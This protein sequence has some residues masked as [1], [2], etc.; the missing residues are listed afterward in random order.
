[1]GTMRLNE[2]DR[3]EAFS[4]SV[5]AVIITIMAFN[6]KPPLGASIHALNGVLP[7]L[8][9]YILSF[10]IVGT[11]WNNHH[12]LL[13]ATERTS[14][15]VMWTN[16]F[17]LFWLSLMPIVTGWVG[18][19]PRHTLPAA[20][21]GVVGLGSAIAYWLLVRMI[22]RANG[23]ASPVARAIG[24]DIKGNLSLVLYASGVA[25][26][27]A[28]PVAAYFLYAAVAVMWFV[29]DRRLVF[30]DEEPLVKRSTYGPTDPRVRVRAPVKRFPLMREDQDDHPYGVPAVGSGPRRQPRRFGLGA[31]GSMLLPP[32]SAVPHRRPP[33]RD[34]RPV[35]NSVVR[36]ARGGR[37]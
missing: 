35:D 14:G 34:G 6:V 13:R 25:I 27:F 17:L 26:A 8:L 33:N 5:M 10:A 11:Y 29:P 19:Y 30:P 20:T 1:M 24:S 16:L 23:A 12:H 2:T 21:Y 22:I 28:S 7:E 36:R 31:G 15:A 32:P 37:T 18:K 4:D 3:L 9:V